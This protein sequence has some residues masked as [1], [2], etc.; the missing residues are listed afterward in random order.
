MAPSNNLTAATAKE[1][2]TGQQ[3]WKVNGSYRRWT[4]ATGVEKDGC[5]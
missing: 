5:G 2:V 3:L 4:A 1:V